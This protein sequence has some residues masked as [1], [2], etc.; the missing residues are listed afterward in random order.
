MRSRTVVAWSGALLA[1]A[2]KWFFPAASWHRGHVIQRTGGDYGDHSKH[3]TTV[4]PVAVPPLHEIL[5]FHHAVGK[6]PQGWSERYWWH[7]LLLCLHAV[8][9][10]PSVR[11]KHQ[12]CI[13]IGDPYIPAT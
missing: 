10:Q 7:E 1:A 5:A 12:T 3:G 9:C 13:L 4:D 6:L 8:S 2:L 11:P